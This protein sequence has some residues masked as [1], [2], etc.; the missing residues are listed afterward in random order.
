M[1]NEPEVTEQRHGLTIKVY[2]DDH[3][4]TPDTEGDD[5]LFLV[6]YHRDCWIEAPRKIIEEADLAMLYRGEKAEHLERIQKEYHVFPVS[7]YIH[8]GVQLSLQ[9]G[10]FHPFDEQGWDTSH[11]GA[12]FVSKAEWRTRK[13]AETVAH[14]LVETWN[15]HL[16]GNVHGYVIEDADGE[17][18]DSCWG[19]VGDVKGEP[20]ALIEA[21]EQVDALTKKGTTDH[22]GQEVLPFMKET[23]GRAPVK[24]DEKEYHRI[25]QE[26]EQKAG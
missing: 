12:V 25:M 15:D 23:E 4:D 18:V 26:G 16:S 24:D 1:N 7:A 17:H 10:N 5:R 20:L 8:S 11:V 19:F 2:Q 21:R 3:Y 14:G 6:H 13:K 9:G 22:R